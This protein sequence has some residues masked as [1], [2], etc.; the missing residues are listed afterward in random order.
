MFE[1]EE[2]KTIPE[3]NHYLIS[4]YGR[5]KNQDTGYIRKLQIKE[6]GGM[7]DLQIFL[8]A[9]GTHVICLVARLVAE[10]FL[11]GYDPRY[12]V[13]HQDADYSNNHISNLI[14]DHSW[15]VR[16]PVRS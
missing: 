6:S 3:N 9:G 1:P 13:V 14:Q 12:S 4:N 2:W 10:A 8:K 5:V 7:G 11:E 15:V 16:K